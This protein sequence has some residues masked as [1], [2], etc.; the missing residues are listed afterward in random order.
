MATQ[1]L[2]DLLPFVSQVKSAYQVR[3]SRRHCWRTAHAGACRSLVEASLGQRDNATQ[4]QKEFLRSTWKVVN[5]TV[6]ACP[7]VGHLN[8]GIHLGFGDTEGA[9]QTLQLAT[10][11]T[12]IFVFGLIG[13]PLGGAPGAM[14]GGAVGGKVMDLGLTDVA[15]ALREKKPDIPEEEEGAEQRDEKAE[16]KKATF[17]FFAGLEKARQGDTGA[18]F[19]LALG[20]IG[21]GALGLLGGQFGVVGAIQHQVGVIEHPVEA[22]SG[23]QAVEQLADQMLT[24]T[25]Q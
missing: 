21:D 2:T 5:A 22:L 20:V 18:E 4:T 19:D 8:A 9:T 10:R 11:T 13:A 14:I 3:A 25:P 12:G 7:V 23:V 1:S 16:P 6:D 17:G 15:E 24:S